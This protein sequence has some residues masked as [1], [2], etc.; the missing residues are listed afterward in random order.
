MEQNTPFFSNSLEDEISTVKVE[1]SAVKVEISVVKVEISAVTGKISETEEN[2]SM[3]I[4]AV[5]GTLGPNEFGIGWD[6]IKNNTDDQRFKKI[7]INA[8][9]E[10]KNDEVYLAL[11]ADKRL[12]MEDKKS[13]MEKER[14][15]MEDKRLLMEKER[16]LM[17]KDLLLSRRKGT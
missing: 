3:R 9:N 5:M 17:E 8:M 2:I 16:L 13:L 12:L 7:R 11:V 15:L 1:I 6:I 10:L 4:E 14:L